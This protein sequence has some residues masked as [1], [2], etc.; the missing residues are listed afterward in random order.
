MQGFTSTISNSMDNTI[1]TVHPKQN[2]S[3]ATNPPKNWKHYCDHDMLTETTYMLVHCTTPTLCMNSFAYFIPNT[4]LPTES[5][6]MND[7]F[8]RIHT[9]EHAVLRNHQRPS[10]FISAKTMRNQPAHKDC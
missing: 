5:E 9:F 4:E 2:N 8:E 1:C 3:H 7:G 6:K 10:R